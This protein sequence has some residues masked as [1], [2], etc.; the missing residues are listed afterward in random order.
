MLSALLLSIASLFHLQ[1]LDIAP[2][3]KHVWWD[4]IQIWYTYAECLTAFYLLPAGAVLNKDIPSKHRQAR[5]D[6]P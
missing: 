1:I 2:L 5:A 6:L 4:H 3:R